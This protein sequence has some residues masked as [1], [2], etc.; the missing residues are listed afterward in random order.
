VV[1]HIVTYALF[2]GTQIAAYALANARV[3]VDSSGD[4]RR[5][6]LGRATLLKPLVDSEAVNLRR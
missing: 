1:A 2:L 5:W 3:E 6:Q 4:R